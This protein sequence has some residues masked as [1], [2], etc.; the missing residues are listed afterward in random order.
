VESKEIHTRQTQSD[1]DGPKPGSLGEYQTQE[2]GHHQD[3][4][5]G[6]LGFIIVEINPAGENCPTHSEEETDQS[7]V[8]FHQA[9]EMVRGLTGFA[10][11]IQEDFPGTVDAHGFL[12]HQLG[13]QWL[14]LVTHSTGSYGHLAGVQ[15]HVATLD[16]LGGQGA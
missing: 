6:G 7:K 2:K 14:N 16:A 12:S 9:T 3:Q 10:F 8:A 15:A 5:E 4:H 1:N 11:P 13:S